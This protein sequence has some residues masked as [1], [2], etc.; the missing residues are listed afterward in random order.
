MTH[1]LFH[2]LSEGQHSPG[3]CG[4]CDRERRS[5]ECVFCDIVDGEERTP[6][7][8][9]RHWM[10]FFPIGPVNSRHTLL[11][12]VRHV[13]RMEDLHGAE[14]ENMLDV[15]WRTLRAL[16]VDEYNIGVNAGAAAGQ[17]VFHLHVHVIPRERGDVADPRGGI[18]TP[19]GERLKGSQFSEY[20]SS[21]PENETDMCL[22]CG[23]PRTSRGVTA[24][25][26][27]WHDDG[28]KP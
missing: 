6:L 18:I 20:L 25:C 24:I 17:T 19:L 13:E 21:L 22:D 28:V 7:V 9:T 5:S 10:S 2:D 15:L 11:V 26:A 16:D 3:T 4:A 1:A 23:Q 12:P 8:R 14:A 27:A